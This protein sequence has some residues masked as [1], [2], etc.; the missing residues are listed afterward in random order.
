MKSTKQILI[1]K[2]SI[3]KR[4]DHYLNEDDIKFLK[5]LVEP[6]N[7][8][9]TLPE[10]NHEIPYEEYDNLIDED[11]NLITDKLHKLRPEIIKGIYDRNEELLDYYER[12][13]DDNPED[14]YLENIVNK[15]TRL[16]K[17]LKNNFPKY[18]NR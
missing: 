15:R 3:T 9:I 18:I 4:G 17:L 10:E 8:F 12:E 16:R 5:K 7:Y 1:D 13:Y 11:F 6:Y 14:E 2:I